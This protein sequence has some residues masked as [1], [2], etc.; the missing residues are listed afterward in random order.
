MYIHRALQDSLLHTSQAFLAVLI[1]GPRQVGKTAPGP[2]AMKHFGILE[3]FN[4]PIGMGA[5]VCL[6]S[7]VIPIT[8]KA[9]AVPAYT[10]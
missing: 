6:A 1:T 4:K 7:R 3:Q 8:E 2:D 9:I 5:V 10:L